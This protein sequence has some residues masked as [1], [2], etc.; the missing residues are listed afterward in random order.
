LAGLPKY[1]IKESRAILRLLEESDAI[2]SKK[3]MTLDDFNEEKK[4]DYS[5]VKE[6]LDNIDVD[7][8]SPRLALDILEELKDMVK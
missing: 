4:I 5:K 7:E 3:Q 1:V 8:I 2:A 6:K